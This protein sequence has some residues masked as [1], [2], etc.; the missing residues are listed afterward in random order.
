M[1]LQEEIVPNLIDSWAE[2]SGVRVFGLT[3]QHSLRDPKGLLGAKFSLLDA[4][5]I[6]YTFLRRTEM[7]SRTLQKSLFHFCAG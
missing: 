7:V 3:G 6:G 2:Q 1:E 4:K 5:F